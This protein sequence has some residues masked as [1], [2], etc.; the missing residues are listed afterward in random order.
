MGKRAPRTQSYPAVQTAVICLVLFGAVWAVFGQTLAHDFVNFDD[1]V[2]VYRNPDVTRGLTSSSIPW[3][4]THRH[5]R[6]WHPL[7]TLSHMLDCSVYGLKAAGH[8]FTNVLLHSITAVVLFFVVRELTHAEGVSAGVAAIWAIHPLRVE[9]VAWI[10][11]RK[12]V[13]SGLL[14]VL[15]LATYLRYA[16]G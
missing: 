10:A 14:F 15:T 6:N 16:R 11:E 9:S 4:F 12:D 3:A 2:Y 7:T 5:A 8:H 13:L 1:E